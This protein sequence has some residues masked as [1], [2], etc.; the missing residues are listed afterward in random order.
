[1]SPVLLR[2]QHLD[3]HPSLT[4]PLPQVPF[5]W[6]Q[7]ILTTYLAMRQMFLGLPM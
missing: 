7:L 4:L 2:H 1:M 5:S 3:R 6:L